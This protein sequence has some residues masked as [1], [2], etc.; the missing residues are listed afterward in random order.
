MVRTFSTCVAAMFL[1]TML[2]TVVT[3]PVLFI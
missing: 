3:S 2:V 1:T